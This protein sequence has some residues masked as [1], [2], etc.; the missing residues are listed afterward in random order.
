MRLTS[1]L[2]LKNESKKISNIE[3]TSKIGLD[4]SW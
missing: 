4:I 1:I 2:V 3:F